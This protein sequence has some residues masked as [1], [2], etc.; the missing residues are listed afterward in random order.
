[1]ESFQVHVHVSGVVSFLYTGTC[2]NNPSVLPFPPA[3]ERERG[4][5]EILFTY[6]VKHSVMN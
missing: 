5:R 6:K 3:R 4:E 1:M 2:F